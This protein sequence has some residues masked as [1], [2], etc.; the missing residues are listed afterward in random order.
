[1]ILETIFKET[2]QNKII[3]EKFTYKLLSHL[4]LLLNLL[5]TIMLKL[6]MKISWLIK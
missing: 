1:M 3:V 6:L 2:L 5:L 4:R